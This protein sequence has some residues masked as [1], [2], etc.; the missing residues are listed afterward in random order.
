MPTISLHSSQRPHI[1]AYACHEDGELDGLEKE[2]I[3]NQ[4][5]EQ[6]WLHRGIRTRPPTSDWGPRLPGV[7]E[8]KETRNGNAVQWGNVD[9]QTPL[10]ALHQQEEQKRI[11][12][13]V[14][15]LSDTRK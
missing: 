13:G 6:E 10:E 8:I 7:F 15:A 1:C 11:R 4:D 2:K 12:T 5:R 9:E 14:L 3:K